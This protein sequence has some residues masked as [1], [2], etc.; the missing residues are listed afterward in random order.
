MLKLS[1]QSV[2]EFKTESFTK[3]IL[4]KTTNSVTFVLHFLPGQKLPVHR[5]SDSEVHL[6]VLEGKGQLVLDGEIM[7]VSAEE[8]VLCGG[9]V[10]FSF[11]NTGQEPVRLY[12]TLTKLPDERYAEN[13]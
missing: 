4:F 12:V 2:R 3:R 10:A 5:H 1:L 8:A 9:D 7:E 13:I 6:L 11:E